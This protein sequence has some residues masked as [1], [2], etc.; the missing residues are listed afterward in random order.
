MSATRTRSFGLLFCGDAE[1]RDATP[2]AIAAPRN[3][4]R[5]AGIRAPVRIRV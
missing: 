1:T 3:C 2:A 4:R 5:E